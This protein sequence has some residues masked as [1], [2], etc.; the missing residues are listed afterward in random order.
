MPIKGS[1]LPTMINLMRILTRTKSQIELAPKRAKS[2]NLAV[3]VQHKLH[4]IT[5]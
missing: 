3:I 1:V 5:K 4:F 2:M